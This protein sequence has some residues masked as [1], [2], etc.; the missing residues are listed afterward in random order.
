MRLDL[1]EFLRRF[2]LHVL[3]KG[4]VRIRHFGFFAHRRR[5]ALLPLCFTLL[6]QTGDSQTVTDSDSG[7]HATAAMALPTVRRRHGDSGAI[8]GLRGA[9]PRSSSE[10]RTTMTCSLSSRISHAW[11]RQPV[12]TARI[13]CRPIVTPRGI[14]PRSLTVPRMR[15]LMPASSASATNN[16]IQ[17]A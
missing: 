1:Y 2:F 16:T 6:G 9:T 5:A 17:N 13:L 14:L 10:K 15:F 12:R 3:P 4:F 7:G 11:G 8:Y